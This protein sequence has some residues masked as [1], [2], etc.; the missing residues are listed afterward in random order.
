M[1]CILDRVIEI[2]YP[3]KTRRRKSFKTGKRKRIG[4]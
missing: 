1:K 2:G 4:W 3:L